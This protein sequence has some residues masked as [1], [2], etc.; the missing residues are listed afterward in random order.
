MPGDPQ[1]RQRPAGHAQDV[2]CRPAGRRWTRGCH[3]GTYDTRPTPLP[4]GG[5]IVCQEFCY[6]S[7]LVDPTKDIPRIWDHPTRPGIDYKRGHRDWSP[8][9]TLRMAAQMALLKRTRGIGRICLDYWTVQKEVAG[10]AVAYRH[11]NRW[12]NST[13][14]QREPTIWGLAYPGPDGAVQ[15][16]RLQTLLEGVQDAEALIYV[17]EAADTRA[18][19]LGPALTAR[20]KAFFLQTIQEGRQHYYSARNRAGWQGRTAQ[21]YALA[22]EVSKSGAGER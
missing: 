5:A 6:G 21:L 17:V 4:G 10:K 15:T 2:R 20:C 19:K 9:D 11:F 3:F 8:L 14:N 22:E 13:C 18:D 7:G 12:P 1:R 16:I